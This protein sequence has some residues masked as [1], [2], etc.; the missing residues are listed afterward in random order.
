MNSDRA[1]LLRKHRNRCLDFTLHR[2]HQIGHLVDDHNDVRQNAAFVCVHFER[3]FRIT[4][5]LQSRPFLHATIEVLHIS[6]AVRG[7]QCVAILHL[8][9]RPLE[10][11]RRIAIVGDHFVSQVR[12]RV[13]HREF[14]HLR[15]D[16]QESQRRRCMPVNQR[17]DDGV[18]AH[19][20][21]GSGRARD[22]QMRHLRQIGDDGTALEILAQRDGQ[23]C[24]RRVVFGVLDDLAE[25]DHLRR[26]IRDLDADRSLPRNRCYDTNAVRAHREREVVRQRR[27]LA[28][29]HARRRLDLELRDRWPGRATNELT[30]DTESLQCRHQPHA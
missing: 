5:L 6:A 2:H 30:L 18:H 25:R 10:H 22:Q 7:Q 26:R 16:H 23:R 19:R 17:R 21:P 29:F 12:Q 13:V 28:H 8:E 4:R 11:R 15:I 20:F 24:A 1:R 3:D 14:D 27:E 9:H